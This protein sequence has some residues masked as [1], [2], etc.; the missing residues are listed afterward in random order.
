MARHVITM[1]DPFND[2]V[3]MVVGW[4][5]ELENTSSHPILF[6]ASSG[7]FTLQ[8]YLTL[9]NAADMIDALASESV[10]IKRQRVAEHHVVDFATLR[11]PIG[12][13]RSPL[14]EGKSDAT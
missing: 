2:R 7:G 9:Q 5:E 14:R 4:S 8:T 12:A 1:R 13:D 11:P 6:T 10:R 3:D